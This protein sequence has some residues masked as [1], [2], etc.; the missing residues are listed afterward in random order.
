[1]GGTAM[2]GIH[3]LVS[4]KH[5]PSPGSNEDAYTH[6]SDLIQDAI[7]HVHPQVKVV[8]CLP[9]RLYLLV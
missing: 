3:V 5:N 6:D 4:F 7:K 8:L 1:M 9:V 2:P